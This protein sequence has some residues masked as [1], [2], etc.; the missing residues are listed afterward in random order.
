MNLEIK[1]LFIINNWAM[2]SGC[3]KDRFYDHSEKYLKLKELF[4]CQ[5]TYNVS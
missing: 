5:Y 4:N 3:I 1:S 2:I